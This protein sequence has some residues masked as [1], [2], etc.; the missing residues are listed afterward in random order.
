MDLLFVQLIV[1]LADSV[2]KIPLMLTGQRPGDAEIVYAA[3]AKA[4]KELKW[5]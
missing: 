3:T 1:R 4:E 5:K 2:Q